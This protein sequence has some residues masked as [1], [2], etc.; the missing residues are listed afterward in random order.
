MI[1]IPNEKLREGY[2]YVLQNHTGYQEDLDKIHPMMSLYL[3]DEGVIGEGMNSRAQFRYHL[4][5]LGK[6][7]AELNYITITRKL[8]KAEL[9]KK[10]NNGL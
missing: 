2:W 8:V 4:T 3:I 6:G 5:E 7:I 9:D 10:K 1:D